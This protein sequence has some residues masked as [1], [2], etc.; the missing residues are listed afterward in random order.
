[1]SLGKMPGKPQ[2]VFHP[3]GWMEPAAKHGVE[4][5][6]RS[7]PRDVIVLGPVL[8]QCMGVRDRLVQGCVCPVSEEYLLC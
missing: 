8:N 4:T 3:Q 6:D 7:E 1:M 5:W 2:G